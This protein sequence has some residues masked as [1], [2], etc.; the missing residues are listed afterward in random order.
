MMIIDLR[1]CDI[2]YRM[3][4][5]PRTL[6]DDGRETII[7][8]LT[9][10]K[11]AAVLAADSPEPNHDSSSNSY[12]QLVIITRIKLHSDK[13]LWILPLTLLMGQFFCL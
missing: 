9:K 12:F 13:D 11:W 6:P 1:D 10:D 2:T 8:H 5:D 3:D 7:P 4:Q